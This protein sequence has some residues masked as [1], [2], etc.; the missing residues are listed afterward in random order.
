MSNLKLDSEPAVLLVDDAPLILD[1]LQEILEDRGYRVLRTESG[2]DVPGILAHEQV[3]VVFCDILL[4]EINGVEVLRQIKQQTPEVQVIIISG[5]QSFDTAREVMRERA[6]DF[7]VKPFAS[8]E[9][10]NAAQRGVTAYYTA[11]NQQKAR[12]EAQRRMADLVLLKQ[13]G[14]SASAGSDLQEL[15]EQIL[16][17][18]V[19]S[20][21]VEIASLMIVGEDKL[22]RISAA[23]GLSPEIV[24]SVLVAPGEGI[25][26]HVFQL[27]EPVLIQNISFDDRFE[28]LVG[29]ERY[30]NQSLLSVPILYRE[31]TLGVINVNNKRSGGAFDAED[32]N[33]LMAI[34][35][36]VALAMENFKLVTSL[37]QQA[38]TLERTNADLVKLNLAR[39]RLV[40]NLSHELKTPLTSIMGFVDLALTFYGRLSEEDLK[41]YLSQAREEGVRLGGL[42]TSMLRLFSIESEREPWKWKA[43][44]LGWAVS[45]AFQYHGKRIERARLKVK[46]AIDEDLPEI[47]GDSEKFGIALNA[48]LDNAVKFNREG[49][50]L[51]VRVERREI[52]G[53]EF[54]YLQIQ[55]DGVTI[56]PEAKATIFDSYTQLGDINTEKP[57]GVGIGLSLVRVVISKMKGRV[58]LESKEGE[59]AS[60]GLLLPSEESYGT[61]RD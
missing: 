59:G 32:Q 53:L 25:A 3:A 39:T 46:V 28:A 14:E 15:F 48:L 20:A 8:G 52:D 57:H 2:K 41:D 34:A 33:L 51:S 4:P 58:F 44:N 19:L 1:L 18:I 26:G 10:L 13:V 9:V 5:Q 42:I 60:F 17:S 23:R 36:Q 30:K 24:N 56:P 11:I 31:K 6:L 49:G 21:G 38:R 37:R 47:Y 12:I 7:L 50:D 54:A 27:R 22:L 35:H 45:E 55:N 43:F 40:C 61:L 29:G 16:D